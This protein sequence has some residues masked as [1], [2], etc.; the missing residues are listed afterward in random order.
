MKPVA[1]LTDIHSCPIHGPNP[2]VKVASKST[3]DG[4]PVATIG[5][6][7]ACGAILVEG[8]AACVTDGKPTVTVGCKT[9]HGGV[10]TTGS[11]TQ[12]I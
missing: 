1:R 4:L 5:D 12:K 10:I 7:T 8:S 3:C 2:I 11:P 6:M 9:S